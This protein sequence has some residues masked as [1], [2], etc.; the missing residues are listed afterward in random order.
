MFTETMQPE[1]A[2]SN[3]CVNCMNTTTQRRAKKGTEYQNNISHGRMSL[4]IETHTLNELTVMIRFT[5]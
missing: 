3:E 2:K 5:V 4:C 1:I